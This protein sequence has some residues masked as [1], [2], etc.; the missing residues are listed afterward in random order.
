ME[1]HFNSAVNFKSKAYPIKP[2]VIKT[3]HGKLKVAEVSPKDL[4]RENFILNLTKLFCKNFA[5]S[6]KDPSWEIFSKPKSIN[7]E[8]SIRDFANYYS[9]KIKSGNDDMTLLLVKDKRNKIQGA[10]LSYGYDRIPE[11]K[12]LVY[13]IDSIA[14]N[15]AYRGFNVGRILLEKTLE[16]AK[17]KFTDA[18]LTGDKEVSRFYEK[19]GFRP[20]NSSIESEKKIIGYI[21]HRRTDYPNY[22]DIFNRPLQESKARWFDI[23]T[24]S[25]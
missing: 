20:L 3:K 7:Y 11:S 12:N 23:I 22:I 4:K 2:F 14:V 21:A 24:I 10:C 13:Y 25:E 19:M 16:S 9:A 8:K 1:I 15:P 6:T 5:S 18:F 17:H